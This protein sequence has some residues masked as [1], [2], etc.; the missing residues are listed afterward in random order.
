MLSYLPYSVYSF[1]QSGG[2]FCWVVRAAPTTAPDNGSMATVDVAGQSGRAFTL[3]ALSPGVWGNSIKYTLSTQGTYPTPAQPGVDPQDIFAIQIVVPNSQGV[4]EVVETFTS[5]SMTGEIPGTRLVATTLNDS[6]SGSRYVTCQNLDTAQLQPKPPTGEGD[7]SILSGGVDP[8]IPD[9]SVLTAAAQTI[10]TVDGPVTLNI[11][12]YMSDIS[13]VDTPDYALKYVSAAVSSYD[14]PDRTDLFVVNDSCPPRPPGTPASTY[15]SSMTSPL[16]PVVGDSYTAAYGPWVIIAHPTRIGASIAVPP[17]GGVMGVMARI[18]ATVGVF[19]APAGVIAGLNNAV[20][21][22]TKFSDT[23]L[24]DLNA[25]NINI[26]RS[27]VGAGICI[28]GGRTR[29]SY[30]ADKYISARRTL[31]YLEESL[32][33]STQYAVFENNDQRLWSSLRMS[34]DR[35]LRPMWERGGLAGASAAEAY[36]ITCNDTINTPSVIQSGEVHMEV[37]V[38]LEYPAEFVIIRIT[39]FDRGTFTSEVTPTS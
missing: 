23:E 13:A 10:A 37:G 26:I 38:A 28:M 24:G 9:P 21:V 25:Q 27:V 19:R 8:G 11:V 35:I 34:A 6:V 3:Q 4:D 39:Q 33:R 17:G 36:Y 22:Q 1:F 5:M 18:D 29:K 15:K 14:F 20:G 7:V 12:G 30:G 16:L 31:I 2:R 32:R